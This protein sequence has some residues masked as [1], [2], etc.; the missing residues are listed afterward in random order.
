[1]GQAICAI[2]IPGRKKMEDQVIH[3]FEGEATVIPVNPEFYGDC[4][5]SL[6]PFLTHILNSANLF[7]ALESSNKVLLPYEGEVEYFEDYS[8]LVSLIKH[9]GSDNFILEY[10]TEIGDHP[11]D[12]L[13]LTVIDGKV[14]PEASNYLDENDN[15][16]HGS[17]WQLLKDLQR[18]FGLTHSWLSNESR[19]FDYYHAQAAYLETK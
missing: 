8:A 10:Y 6:N 16:N 5:L 7:S 14:V 17:T 2:I 12:H 11:D 18:K 13:Y 1:M 9:A 3:F 15:D 4:S 19:Y